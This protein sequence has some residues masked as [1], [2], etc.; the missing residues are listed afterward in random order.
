MGE[1]DNMAKN[2]SVSLFAFVLSALGLMANVVAIGTSSWLISVKY[3]K[4]SIG[5]FRHCD[6]DSK[7]CGG[8]SEIS[9]IVDAQEV[10]ELLN[11]KIF[12]LNNPP[13]SS[14]PVNL[15]VIICDIYLTQTQAHSTTSTIAH[16]LLN[17]VAR[18]T[19][20]VRLKWCWRRN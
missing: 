17:V 9:A 16:P 2:S 10:G 18:F 15:Y 14:T 5:V 13:P 12:P 20:Y 3:L 1:Q 19:N 8:M 6:Y 11:R 7:Y 4:M